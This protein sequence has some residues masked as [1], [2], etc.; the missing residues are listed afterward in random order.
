MPLYRSYPQIYIA[1][2]YLANSGS[3]TNSTSGAWQDVAAGGGTDSWTSE[4]DIRPAGATAQV[5]TTTDAAKLTCQKAGVYM[6]T[7][8]VQFNSI[9]TAAKTLGVSASLNSTTV[10]A[11][12]D[13]RG[14]GVLGS[15]ALSVCGPMVLIVGDV[16][17]LLSF[18]DDAASSAYNTT[19]TSRNRLTMSYIGPSS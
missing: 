6:V 14:A 2:V 17:R 13:V 7:A 15:L 8:S 1:S 9:G 19:V 4:Y 18:Q 5:T 11:L 12:A 10:P 3:P 16:L